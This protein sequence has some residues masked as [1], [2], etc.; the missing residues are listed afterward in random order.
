MDQNKHSIK[1]MV[2]AS[3]L[4]TRTLQHY[5]KI[6]LLP[7]SGRTEGGRR[8][9]TEADLVRLEQI[10]FYKSLGFSLKQIRENLIN[11]PD[12]PA[13]ERILAEQ[14]RILYL[15]IEAMHTS[16]AALEACRE[17]IKAKRIPPWKFLSSFIS[18]LGQKD[19]HSW[20][21]STIDPKVIQEISA[22]FPNLEEMIG[23]LH[24]W[25]KLSIKAAVFKAAGIS[26]QEPVAQEL[27]AEWVKMAQAATGGNAKLLKGFLQIDQNRESWPEGARKLM[28]EA[29]DYI[30]ECYRVYCQRNDLEPVW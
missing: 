30:T 18:N 21:F 25:K 3:G 22:H 5:D 20:D 8:F 23:L 4:T 11:P 13:M 7:A 16:L 2:A 24:A 6:G 9:Y 28:E 17:V 27:A 26:P 29:D 12:L 10:I 14:A 1:E 19:F 15:Q